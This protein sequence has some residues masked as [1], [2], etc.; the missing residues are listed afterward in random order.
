M[1]RTAAYLG[2][3]RC[4]GQ[5]TNTLQNGPAA[6]RNARTDAPAFRIMQSR[7]RNGMMAER[8]VGRW[9]ARIAHGHGHG[10]SYH[11]YFTAGATA[12]REMH[13]G[14]LPP[15]MATPVAPRPRAFPYI[16]LHVVS[17]C[18]WATHLD[19]R[20]GCTMCWWLYHKQ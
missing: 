7:A 19:A 1:I 20:L 2:V 8:S 4:R 12:S 10:M 5:A 15:A 13:V 9:T 14:R 16:M 17:H 18:G 6:W 11:N 3:Q